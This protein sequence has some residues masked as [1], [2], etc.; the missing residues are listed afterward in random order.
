M[1]RLDNTADMIG[2]TRRFLVSKTKRT[3]GVADRASCNLSWL[4]DRLKR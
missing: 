1:D 3:A 2:A 4:L